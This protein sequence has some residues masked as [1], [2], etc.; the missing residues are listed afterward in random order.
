MR[1]DDLAD[2]IEA[3]YKTGG[4]SE[5]RL[6]MLDY[7]VKLT[8]NPGSVTEHD[9]E[10]LRDVEFTDTDILHIAEVVGYY[11]YANRIADGLG[12]PLEDWI[13]GEES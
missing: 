1:D 6:A 13:P 8:V 5:K 3:D 11:A 2:R 9:V 12:I 4:V 10:R 7:A